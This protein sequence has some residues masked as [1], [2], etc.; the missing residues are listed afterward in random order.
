MREL[1][2]KGIIWTW[3]APGDKG[4]TLAPKLCGSLCESLLQPQHHLSQGSRPPPPP[5]LEPVQNGYWVEN[6]TQSWA[7]L[8]IFDA[9]P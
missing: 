4:Q 1:Q 8:Q 9:S 2:G 7:V 5:N 6:G 3:S